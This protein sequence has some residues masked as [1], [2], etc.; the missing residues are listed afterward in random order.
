MFTAW[1]RARRDAPKEAQGK[2]CFVINIRDRS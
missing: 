1:E 2:L